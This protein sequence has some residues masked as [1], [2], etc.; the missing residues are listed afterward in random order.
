M[1]FSRV[2]PT[3]GKRI[4]LSVMML[5]LFMAVILGVSASRL[6]LEAA[7]PAEPAVSATALVYG[8]GESTV[9][10]EIPEKK[11]TL[12][13]REVI[14]D[15]SVL[16]SDAFVTG[17]STVTFLLF[18]DLLLSGVLERESSPM[19]GVRNCSGRILEKEHGYFSFSFD[20]AGRSLTQIEV[21][22]D[23]IAYIISEDTLSGNY[24]VVEL[25]LDQ[26][27]TAASYAPLSAPVPES[28]DDLVAMEE[29]DS[30]A[31]ID[32]LVA[33]TPEAEAW[34]DANR[35]GIANVLAQSLERANQ[36]FADSEVD[37]R[38][39]L[40]LAA[41]VAY[42]ESG[43]ANT[44]LFRA[45]FSADF[46]PDGLDTEGALDELQ[47]W[48]ESCGADLVVLMTAGANGAAW[49]MKD[50][51]GDARYGF[52]VVPVQNADVAL[53][54]QTGYNLGCNNSRNQ[55]E[56]PA[57]EEGGL[58]DFSTGARWVGDDGQGYASIMTCPE[59]DLQV[60]LFSNPEINFAG[61]PTGAYDGPGAPADNARSLRA[62]MARV[63]AY[64]E[65]KTPEE[66]EGGP[67]E[68]ESA[69]SDNQNEDD[70]DGESIS[71]KTGASDAAMDKAVA[72][73]RIYIFGGTYG[74]TG[75]DPLGFDKLLADNVYKMTTSPP[76]GHV[77]ES[78]SY[79]SEF[80]Y[81]AGHA[82]IVNSQGL[83]LL[84]GFSNIAASP[85][86]NEIWLLKAN[87]ETW[88]RRVTYAAWEGR[89][90]H[91][92]LFFDGKAW[93]L[94]GYR[95]KTSTSEE[96]FYND[97]FYSGDVMTWTQKTAAANWAARTYHTSAVFD[98]KMYVMGGAAKDTEG[99]LARFDDI[100]YSEDGGNWTQE[101]PGTHWSPRYGHTS[102]V[103]EITPGQPRIFVMGG[104]V[105]DDF[106][107]KSSYANDVW[108]SEDGINWTEETG[109]AGWAG[110]REHAS[111]VYDGKIWVIGG[112][113]RDGGTSHDLRDVWYSTNGRDWVM[114]DPQPSWFARRGLS[115][116]VFPA[117][118]GGE[119]EGETE[120]EGPT[121][122]ETEGETE[123]V[124][125]ADLSIESKV[126]DKE[127]LLPLHDWVPLF[128]IAM[129]FEDDN[130][131]PRY[132][133]RLVYRLVNDD[134]FDDERGLNYQV[135][136]DLDASD[137]LEFGIFNDFNVEGDQ[138]GVA[139]N[140]NLDSGD[141]LLFSWDSHGY[142]RGRLLTANPVEGS[143]LLYDITFDY[144]N[145]LYNLSA[146]CTCDGEGS[147]Y[148]VA[149]RTSATWRSQLSLGVEVLEAEMVT[150]AGVRP[151][152]EEGAPIDSYSPDFYGEDPE[153]LEAGAFYSASFGAYDPSG[154]DFSSMPVVS[155]WG[156]VPTPNFWQRTPHLA[157]PLAEF[158]RPRWNKPL[159][160]MTIATGQF[161]E[162]RNLLSMDDWTAVVGINLH[163]SRSYSGGLNDQGKAVLREVNVILTDVGG[164]PY[165]EPGNGGFNPRNALKPVIDAR[166]DGGTD[167]HHVCHN[168]LWVWHDTNNNQLFDVPTPQLVGGVSFSGDEPL[169]SYENY[170]E[171][172]YIPEPPGGGDPWWK[173]R[174]RFLGT[175]EYPQA[176]VE[177]P[178]D[179]A[180]FNFD[181]DGV[182]VSSEFSYDYFVV[183][184]FDSGFRDCSLRP[185]TNAGARPGAEFRA[186]IEPRRYDVIAGS[187]TGGI[188]VDSQIPTMD[189][190]LPVGPW[191][192]DPRWFDEP[193]W[194]ERT[195]N[196]DAAKP[197][198]LGVEV[199]DL[200]LTYKP[201]VD[202]NDYRM[203]LEDPLQ[204]LFMLTPNYLI[205]ENLELSFQSLGYVP[206][207]NMLPSLLGLWTDPLGLAMSQFQNGHYPEIYT[208]FPVE[209]SLTSS[210][211]GNTFQLLTTRWPY[212]QDC[213]ENAPF[214]SDYTDV[215]PQGPRSA[216]Y[217]VPPEA[218]VT[219]SYLTWP[220]QPVRGQYPRFSDWDP[221]DARAR[222]LTQKISANSKHTPMLGIN[223][224]GSV[225]P[226]V[227]SEGNS[228]SLAE[229]NVAFWGPD[230]SPDILKP[231]DP[232]NNKNQSLA[233]GVLLW[234]NDPA[235]PTSIFMPRVFFN[236]E[237]LDGY[238]D[239]PLPMFHRIVPVT[240]AKWGVAPELVD[241]SGDGL[242]D[243]LD[244]NGY[245]DEADKAWVLTLAPGA[246][247]ELPQN[248]VPGTE[249][250]GLDLYITVKTSDQIGRFQKFRAVVPATLPSRPSN[251]RDAGIQFYPALNTSSRAYLKAHGDEGPVQEYY[252][253]DMME[254]NVP[255][256]IVDMTQ[257]W[258]D[259]NIGGSAVPVLGLDIATNR[260][261]GTR[262]QGN[263]G[264]GSPGTFVVDT[265]NWVA[266]AFAGDFLIDERFE[267]YEILSNTSNA[268]MLR[269]G[270][271]RGGAWRIVQDPTFLEE[272]TVELYQ[273]GT[274]ATFNP[275]TDLLPLDIDQR[276][277]GVAIYR[278]N[279][280]HPNNRNGLFDPDIDIPMSLDTPPR[281]TGRN[282]E[283]IKVRF[284]FSLPGTRDFPLPIADQP[285]NRQWVPDTFGTA[286]GDP[287][288]GSDFI[289]VLRAAQ[290][291]QVG[292][293]LRAGIVS[294]GPNTPTEPDPHIWAGFETDGQYDYL[295]FREFPWA[296]RGVGFVTFFKEA[297]TWYFMN[298]YNGVQ[299]PDT[300][301]YNWIR[302]SSTEK[303]RSGLVTARNRPIGP[304]TIEITSVSQSVLPIQTLPGQGFSFV[305]YGTN[306]GTNPTVVLSGYNVTVDS[307]T[308]TAIRI[309]IES[310]DDVV[311][312]E[313]VTLIV[314]NPETG[315][316]VSRSDLF[317]LTGNMSI[318][319]PK[320]LRV[321][322]SSGRKD[323]FPVTILGENFF[324]TANLAV[325]FDG[326][327][328]PI[329]DVSADG[330]AITVGFPIGG[331]PQPGLLDVSVS[332]TG[333]NSGKDI[334]I[335][336]FEY[337]NPESREKVRFFGCSPATGESAG[338]FGD[339][340]LLAALVVLLAVSGRRRGVQS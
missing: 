5:P 304:Q 23:R 175:D 50:P 136:Q 312:Q 283:D 143:N 265:V 183:A 30:S 49:L 309:T 276:I 96:K 156:T 270:T 127:A 133:K 142:D 103:F 291:M 193:F 255:M 199:H 63:A 274:V 257:R 227:N 115:A 27:H 261:D 339:L 282:A 65:E 311:P 338:I 209:I 318:T 80:G 172:E 222:L 85:D 137:L 162:F 154:P 322:P 124:P 20:D 246:N 33:Y 303:R 241:L 94:G 178:P 70:K 298:G 299:R 248:D 101:T 141:E 234:D 134:S 12:R 109:N 191:Q 215:A 59:G 329:L 200:V 190:P 7:V 105:G 145:R 244:G 316:E 219:P 254:A 177:A 125:A 226:V 260:A 126:R 319:G 253:H 290:G 168:G 169:Y 223:L 323:D 2:S 326:T 194:P 108:S 330:T 47:E 79:N 310:R 146:S 320:L 140:G 336:G 249:T 245:V 69:E 9:Y 3:K 8:V 192:N 77:W 71:E 196:A 88:E 155:E 129:S 295:K 324:D 138:A 113:Y 121:E 214:Y 202:L 325:H 210:I 240:G 286:A 296:D 44:D 293:N 56:N 21:L 216:A 110:R 327:L 118:G 152:D 87:D 233:S 167:G 263:F 235:A 328:M 42:Q 197:F 139:R 251:Q 17:E 57:A 123:E 164:D 173:M 24:Y 1:I 78:K 43:D 51:A 236:T 48:R 205:A 159:Q 218:P 14:V 181:D 182:K 208:F 16:E 92:A 185:A 36:T 91:T 106:T 269:S 54:R 82:N 158:S 84:G 74:Y 301:G 98:G 307:A 55:Q 18:D 132:L 53:V 231:L 237:E 117:E 188:Y 46:D 90:G 280:N 305:I 111:V 273:E 35:S 187:W 160:L 314:R 212:P 13:R 170:Y 45:T 60:F 100:W 206:V 66:G 52:S 221:A 230:F 292:D 40:V 11:Q 198:R 58:Y 288:N 165:G 64:R 213:F 340:V 203:L 29:N 107:N 72:E 26:V 148:I 93:L 176:Y 149:V 28:G 224:T 242:A 116:A 243:D 266:N 114:A 275:L 76:A 331:L 37:L 131:A 122:G 10:S 337:I 184:R 25:P 180:S 73:P 61:V 284:A 201:E 97:V 335:D 321:D 163:A 267:S 195:L 102:V 211:F 278:D 217:P 81:R 229:V 252:G 189:L 220:G 128:R 38:L 317:S 135:I 157:I 308:D 75:E 174:L 4:L 68:G 300:S 262:A 228:A 130:P 302:S 333:A 15:K 204:Y 271:P 277:S 86:R 306:F 285:R 287:A 256:K 32:V 95:A 112:W 99:S 281:F 144:T 39:R 83:W 67:E 239:S 250:G 225:D 41:P 315:E 207:E 272:V 89:R 259:I 166:A 31:G 171:W 289:V 34:A 22:E 294:Y 150:P 153:T 334:L 297:P 6:P 232:D 268:L 279:D 313:P 119:G 332:S 19:P 120:G 247:W 147:T 62:A 104:Q 186:F 238:G 161:M 264:T 258:T 179:N 151:V